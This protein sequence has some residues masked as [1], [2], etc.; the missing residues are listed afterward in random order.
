MT[1]DE[2]I[3]KL[4]AIPGDDNV[5]IV[6]DGEPYEIHGIEQDPTDGAIMIVADD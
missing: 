1:K 2:L 6:V 5:I 3:K 4:D